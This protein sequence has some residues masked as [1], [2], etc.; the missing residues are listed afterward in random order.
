M[1][2]F[3]ESS[4]PGIVFKDVA[5]GDLKTFVFQNELATNA[6]KLQLVSVTF[7]LLVYGCAQPILPKMQQVA[8]ALTF[9]A[10]FL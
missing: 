3:D 2:E 1:N 7:N 8:D 5:F 6:T 4:L 9:R 10:S